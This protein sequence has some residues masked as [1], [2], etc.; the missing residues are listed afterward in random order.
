MEEIDNKDIDPW[1]RRRLAENVRRLRKEKKLSQERLSE[2][3]GFHRTYISQVERSIINITLD[4]LQR[5]M[6]A[7]GSD[8]EELFANPEAKKVAAGP[9]PQAEKKRSR[10]RRLNAQG[11]DDIKKPS[12]G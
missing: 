9:Q 11:L 12:K 7:L 5:I 3:C 2:S 1:L 8:P 10:T 6:A 4:N